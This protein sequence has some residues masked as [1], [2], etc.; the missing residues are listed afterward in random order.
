MC[1]KLLK[2]IPVLSSQ[3]YEI[4]IKKKKPKKKSQDY[5]KKN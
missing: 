5:E 3:I 4:N 1:K 2:K